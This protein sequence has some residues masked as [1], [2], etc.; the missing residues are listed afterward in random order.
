MNQ[1]IHQNLAIEK[2]IFSFKFEDFQLEGYYPHPHIK[3]VVS[4]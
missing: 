2:N 1:T 4:V 3:G